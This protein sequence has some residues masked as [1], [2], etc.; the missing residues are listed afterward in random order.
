VRRYIHRFNRAGSEGLSPHYGRGRL[1]WTQL[2]RQ[3]SDEK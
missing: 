2:S 3:K 1:R